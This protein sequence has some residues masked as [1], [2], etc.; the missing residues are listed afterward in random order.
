MNNDWQGEGLAHNAL[1]VMFSYLG[2]FISRAHTHSVFILN[3][4][5]D[6]TLA[7]G[8]IGNTWDFDSHILSSSL[9]SSAKLPEVQGIGAEERRSII[10]EGEKKTQPCVAVDAK[11][12]EKICG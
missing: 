7:I 2:L 10:F 5:W 9:G 8:V 11:T 1:L 6:F 3:L 12:I 4:I